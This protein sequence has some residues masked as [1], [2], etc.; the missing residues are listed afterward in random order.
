MV[1]MSDIAWIKSSRCGDGPTCVEVAFPGPGIAV[2]D[3]KSPV[4]EIA[5]DRS[6]WRAFLGAVSRGEPG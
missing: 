3:A 5:F 4:G 6:A 1:A 2:R